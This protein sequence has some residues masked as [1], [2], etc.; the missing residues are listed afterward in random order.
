M[1]IFLCLSKVKVNDFLRSLKQI[2]G[3]KQK[4]LKNGAD[5]FHESNFPIIIPVSVFQ[6]LMD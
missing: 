6:Q 4:K 3:K 2:L 5:Q 1:N